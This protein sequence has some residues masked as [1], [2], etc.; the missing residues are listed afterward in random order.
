MPSNTTDSVKAVVTSIF[1]NLFKRTEP[2]TNT[3]KKSKQV[4]VVKAS[5][6]AL[7]FSKSAPISPLSLQYYQYYL[8][9]ANE[10]ISFQ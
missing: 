4:C 10:V 5:A 1:V 9:P 8:I 3:A 6:A 7:P 2:H